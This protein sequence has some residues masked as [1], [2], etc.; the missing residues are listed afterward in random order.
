MSG[1]AGEQSTI[2]TTFEAAWAGR[3]PIAW[4]NAP[5]DP[6]KD[7]ANA[8]TK[9]LQPWVRVSGLSGEAHLN[10]FGAGGRYRHPGVAIVQVFVPKDSGTGAAD[11]YIDAAGAIFRGRSIGGIIFRAPYRDGTG[12]IDGPWYTVNLNVPFLRDE[13]FT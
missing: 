9:A 3:T 2:R 8:S 10:E 7:A 11:G 6:A 1:Y 4:E 5:F 13:S 12:R